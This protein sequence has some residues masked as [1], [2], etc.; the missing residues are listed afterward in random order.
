MISAELCAAGSFSLIVAMSSRASLKIPIR[1]ASLLLF[2][3][4]K[5]PARERLR[6]DRL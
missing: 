2:D 6:R 5:A 4:A 3:I 1:D